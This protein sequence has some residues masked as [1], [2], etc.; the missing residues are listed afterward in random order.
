M[1]EHESLMMMKTEL[2]KPKQ[3]Q[4]KAMLL[5]LQRSTFKKRRQYL[6]SVEDGNIK[7]I[8]EKYPVLGVAEFVSN[9]STLYFEN[10]RTDYNIFLV[11]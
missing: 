10:S 1:N 4:D 6:Q 2:D 9:N 5:R 7:A 3:D 8:V 11:T